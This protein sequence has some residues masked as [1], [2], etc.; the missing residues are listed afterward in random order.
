MTLVFNPSMSQDGKTLYFTDVSPYPATGPGSRDTLA[1]V[2]VMQYNLSGGFQL[3]LPSDYLGES[4]VNFSYDVTS[5]DGV[6]KALFFALPLYTGQALA[7]GDIVFQVSNQTILQQIGPD[8]I[9]I[10]I[11]QLIDNEDLLDVGDRYALIVTDLTVK[12]DTLLLA[13]LEKMKDCDAE[14]CSY[15]EVVQAKKNY[16]YIRLM[17]YA[18][19]IEFCRGNYI[20]AQKYIEDANAFS[21]SALEANS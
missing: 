13:Y 11:S 9:E 17:R 5:K 14:C 3:I 21:D 15:D 7:E 8:L 10:P 2:A 1:I 6:M 19:Y 20:T 16:D 18:A 4:V 12:R